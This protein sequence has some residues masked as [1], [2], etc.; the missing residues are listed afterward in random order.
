VVGIDPNRD[1][2]VE[3]KESAE[4]AGLE[5]AKYVVG[6]AYRLN[7]ENA[8]F[9]LVCSNAVLEWIGEPVVLLTELARVTRSGGWVIAMVTSWEQV[10][11]YPDCPSLRS[12]FVGLTAH[13]QPP[14]GVGFYNNH[15]P[16]QAFSWLVSAGFEDRRLIGFTPDL[17]VAYKGSEHF[18]YRY[19][20]LKTFA[21]P[22]TSWD[23][24]ISSGMVR[25][26]ATEGANIELDKWHDHPHAFFM[27]PRLAACGR[28]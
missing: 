7:F 1:V 13:E 3:A 28:V 6:D 5:N 20:T 8:S 27:Q 21:G 25:E 12:F 4:K 2:I 24:L 10:A 15:A 26:E 19:R 23:Y 16:H 18:E 14:Q 11:M 22:A 9:D 17:D